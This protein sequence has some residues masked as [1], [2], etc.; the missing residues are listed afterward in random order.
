MELNRSNVT[1]NMLQGSD[2]T[3]SGGA[4]QW[5]SRQ[6]NPWTCHFG[7]STGSWK[8][9]LDGAEETTRT[10]WLDSKLMYLC[11][12]WPQLAVK[13]CRQLNINFMIYWEHQFIVCSCHCTGPQVWLSVLFPLTELIGA[14]L[15]SLFFDGLLSGNCYLFLQLSKVVLSFYIPSS[16]Y[17]DIIL[18]S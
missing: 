14:R 8:Y 9:H 3:L 13:Y 4:T 1:G 15:F 2:L 6:E 5:Q 11:F 12:S 16:S 18:C 7:V 10:S 17:S